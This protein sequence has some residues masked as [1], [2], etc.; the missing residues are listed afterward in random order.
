MKAIKVIILDDDAFLLKVLQRTIHRAFPEVDIITTADI[1][2]F[3]Q[4]LSTT[5]DVDLVLS[6]YLMPQMNGLD[7][8]EQCSSK[9]PY[10]VR[11]L[12]T[13]DMR[14]STMIQQPNIVHAYLAKP[15]NEADIAALF[16]NVAAL[17]SLPF[18]YNVR[19]QLGAMVSFPVYPLIL[20]ELRDL[21][22]SDEFDLHDIAHVVSQEP[23]ITAKLLQLAN[24]AYLGFVRPT[25]SID[26]AVSRL[27]TTI[28]MAIT[29]S[30]LVAKNFESSIPVDVHEK[31]LN[32]AANYASCVKDFAKL[33]GFNLHDQELLFSVALLSFV[34]KIILLSQAQSDVSDEHAQTIS[35]G[36]V[37]ANF[38]SAYVL[39]LWGYDT[40][41]CNLL[42]SCHD[43][44]GTDDNELTLFNHMLYIVWQIIFDEQPP[45]QLR[46]YCDSKGVDPLL[47][48]VISEFDWHSY[49][50]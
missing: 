27:G 19:R 5:K 24:S 4:L 32:I 16:N 28:L 38:I 44:D 41:I 30:L 8:L 39:K 1:D 9:N 35:D 50:S 47:C 46:A 36:Y 42:M 3:W 23:I 26:E 48:H 43:L 11:A 21:V 40:K 37:S 6:D 25:S 29:T 14:L 31:Q 45:M 34:G 20:K 33:A 7:I 22:Q 12:L 10:P 17:K 2:E 49:T 18:A 13:G 15:F